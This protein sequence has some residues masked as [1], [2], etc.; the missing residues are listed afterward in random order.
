MQALP[1]KRRTRQRFT[2][3][4]YK[5]PLACGFVW[6]ARLSMNISFI[7]F[8]EELKMCFILNYGV[9]RALVMKHVMPCMGTLSML[10]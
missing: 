4:D 1:L 10:F 9:N 5:N 6:S 8:I 3:I 2:E 7:T